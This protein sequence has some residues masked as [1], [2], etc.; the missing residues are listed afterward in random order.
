M[1]YERDPRIGDREAT[2]YISNELSVGRPVGLV[3]TPDLD[4]FYRIHR[5]RDMDLVTLG[6][7][8]RLS[9]NPDDRPRGEVDTGVFPVFKPELVTPAEINSLTIAMLVESHIPVYSSLLTSDPD[10]RM[11]FQDADFGIL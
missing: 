2:T 1:N 5:R 10:N 9:I 4:A 11:D 7:A 6:T 3:G 8:L